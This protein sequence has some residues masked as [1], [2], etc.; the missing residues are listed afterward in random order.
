MTITLEGSWGMSFSVMVEVTEDRLLQAAVECMLRYDNGLGRKTLSSW[1]AVFL[2]TLA[3]GE[4]GSRS[5]I[6]NQL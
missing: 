5:R 6:N 1:G 3:V 4:T 2:Y